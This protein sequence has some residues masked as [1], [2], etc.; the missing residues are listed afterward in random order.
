[1]NK[2][3]RTLTRVLVN[4]SLVLIIILLLS[5]TKGFLQ[6]V[7]N[8]ILFIL[9]PTILSLYV[10]YALRPLKLFLHKY[11]QNESLAA[12]LT[13][14]C[15]LILIAI[16]VALLSNVIISQV[17]QLM[18]YNLNL[19]QFLKN[20]SE[21]MDWMQKNLDLEGQLQNLEQSI[22]K[23]ASNLPSYIQG[24]FSG[25]SN[26]ATQFITGLLCLFYLLKDEKLL[27]EKILSAFRGPYQKILNHMGISIHE[28]LKTYISG[29]LLVAVILGGLMF[30]GFLIIKLPYAALMAVIALF[31]NFIPFIGPIIGCIPAILVA[32]TVNFSMIVKV[33]VVTI[34]VQQL[35]SNVI[36]PNIMGSKMDIHPFL[37]IVV[38]L[39]C[40]NLFGVLGALIATPLYITLKII[41]QSLLKIRDQKKK[42]CRISDQDFY[43]K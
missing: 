25:V 6:P 40:M 38:V 31:T 4:I 35:E 34:I 42:L 36:T 19:D 32:M 15:F 13:F 41:I 17:Q 10:F 24:A 16:L 1:M 9:G 7:Y 30:I 3:K 43:Q 12:F 23:I 2:E 8:V 29:Q 27:A 28:S 37:V 20:N 21:V 33:V 26:F 14:L 39:I 18:T 11:I 5:L 22:R